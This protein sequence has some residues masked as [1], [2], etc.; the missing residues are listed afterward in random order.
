MNTIT[1]T[2]LEFLFD[3]FHMKELLAK[4]DE[5]YATYDVM[6]TPVFRVTKT[7]NEQEPYRV[8]FEMKYADF[9]S[10]LTEQLCAGELDLE[11]W[12]RK[13][14][15]T[16]SNWQDRTEKQKIKLTVEDVVKRKVTNEARMKRARTRDAKQRE[17]KLMYNPGNLD[18]EFEVLSDWE[19]ETRGLPELSDLGCR[20]LERINEREMTKKNCARELGMTYKNPDNTETC[21]A[22]FGTAWKELV[23]RGNISITE[24]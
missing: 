12:R 6:R 1:R 11:I 8:Y 17:M 2:Q 18:E 19:E 23:A 15:A 16:F 24:T 22:E 21:N 3:A 13:F 4:C 7:G 10:F 14:Y 9:S 20:I 5:H